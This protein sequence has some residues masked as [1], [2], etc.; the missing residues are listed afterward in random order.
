MEL[1]K[2]IDVICIIGRPTCR[3]LLISRL[4]FG[5]LPEEALSFTRAYVP[6]SGG[7]RMHRPSANT[8]ICCSTES[9]MMRIAGVSASDDD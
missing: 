5:L 3:N 6:G 1:E 7:G 4:P 8:A 2:I 9:I